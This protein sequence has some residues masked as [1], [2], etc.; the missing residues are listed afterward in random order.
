MNKIIVYFGYNLK[1]IIPYNVIVQRRLRSELRRATDQRAVEGPHIHNA[2]ANRFVTAHQ[3]W[4]ARFRHV[5]SFAR[6]GCATLWR[7]DV[8]HDNDDTLFYFKKCIVRL[9]WMDR[10]EWTSINYNYKHLH[11]PNYKHLHLGE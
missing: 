2:H 8:G 7:S 10:I 1:C 4:R 3:K 9:K 11:V 5:M 6:S